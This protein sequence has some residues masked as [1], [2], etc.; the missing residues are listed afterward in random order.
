MKTLL[1]CAILGGLIVFLWGTFS[2]TVL[3]WHQNSFKQ[4]KNE[5]KVANAIRENAV[6]EGIYL[7]PSMFAYDKHESK[8][9]S[10]QRAAEGK[11]KMMRGPVM[12]A[13]IKPFG[14]DPNL[15]RPMFVGVLLNMV[16]AF[17]ISWIVS[18]IKS[19]FWGYTGYVTLI[20]VIVGILSFFPEWNWW[21]FPLS[22][23]MVGLMDLLI[24]WFLAGMFIARFLSK[25]AI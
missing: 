22:Y 16:G 4:F 3:P 13:S 23:A 10:K 5:E 9:E 21:N 25:R 17:L 19:D 1:R 15:A 11:D 20:G 24:G 14:I 7:L 2:W 6:E 8:G 12:F 18:K